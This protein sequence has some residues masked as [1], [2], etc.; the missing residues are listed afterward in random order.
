MCILAGMIDR[1]DVDTLNK[2]T[3]VS[4]ENEPTALNLAYADLSASLALFNHNIIVH[5]LLS[6]RL[7]VIALQKPRQKKSQTLWEIYLKH[8]FVS[9]TDFI[10]FRFFF[11]DHYLV[12]FV[13]AANFH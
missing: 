8:Q 1:L 2:D 5:K 6:N 11:S 12:I 13:K 7:Q 3:V 4:V 9:L 10:G